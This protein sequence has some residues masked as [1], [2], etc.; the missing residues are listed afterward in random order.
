MGRRTPEYCADADPLANS[1]AP[2]PGSTGAHRLPN[3]AREAEGGPGRVPCRQRTGAELP[4]RLPE[5][6]THPLRTSS[7]GPTVVVA[8]R[9]RRGW[10]RLDGDVT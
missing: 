2:R 8:P 5:D 4:E 1:H 10:A 6:P 9:I 7:S 3:G